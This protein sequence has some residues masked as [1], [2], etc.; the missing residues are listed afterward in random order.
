ME[1]KLHV[2]GLRIMTKNEKLAVKIIDTVAIVLIAALIGFMFWYQI[3]TL[4]PDVTFKWGID[5]SH[6]SVI[7]AM[8]KIRKKTV[9]EHVKQLTED[10][11][12]FMRA[13]EY[14]EGTTLHAL[15]HKIAS[16]L[17]PEYD[18]AM[19]RH[20]R[21]LTDDDLPPFRDE[22]LMSREES[23]LYDR[24]AARK[25]NLTNEEKQMISQIERSIAE[26]RKGLPL[27]KRNEFR[28]EPLKHYVLREYQQNIAKDIKDAIKEEL[29]KIS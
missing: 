4:N 18:K 5:R 21:I 10:E 20:L 22:W 11:M 15:V 1:H 14:K 8:E 19:Q 16:E 29:K 28:A 27:S 25:N 23:A 17:K 12:I 24:L 2:K 9:R 3:K 6:E 26:R 13:E 7:R